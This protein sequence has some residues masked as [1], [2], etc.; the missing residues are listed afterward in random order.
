MKK[1]FLGLSLVA[2]LGATPMSIAFAD[3]HE[4]P[5]IDFRESLMTIFKWHLKPMA[6]MI[7]GKIPFNEAA[8]RKNAN[9]LAAATSLDLLSGFPRGSIEDSE[10]KPEI[11]R[12]WPDFKDKFRTLQR[13]SAKLKQAAA[14][15]D[16]AAMKA[17][18]IRTAKVC[19]G[20]HKKFREK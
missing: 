7:K 5:A 13:E 12:H 20:C 9:G 6:G 15:G 10:A 2:V 1:F 8:F 4:N 14:S 16:R 19:K 18:F 3:E 11:W 17:Q